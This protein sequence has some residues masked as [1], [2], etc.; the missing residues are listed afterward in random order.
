MTTVLREL[1][2]AV[3]VTAVALTLAACAPL[4]VST[5]VERGIDLAA[6][7]SYGWSVQDARPTGDPRLDGNTFVHDYVVAAIDRQMRATG[8]DPNGDAPDLLV[9]YSAG[10]SQEVYTTGG[11]EADDRCRDCRLEVYD[12]GTLVIDFIDARTRRLV[13]RGWARGAIDG[14]ISDQRLMKQRVEGAVVRIFEE[15]RARKKKA[16]GD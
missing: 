16:A 9:R 2:L 15:E 6:Y 10:V 4:T 12:S 3:P 5:S 11:T 1:R 8:L 14:A 7:C 13:W